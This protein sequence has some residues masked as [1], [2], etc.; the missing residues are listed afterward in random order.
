[1]RQIRSEIVLFISLNKGGTGSTSWEYRQEHP[2]MGKH[3]NK[4]MIFFSLYLAQMFLDNYDFSA[5]TSIVDMGGG[6]G[7]L[8]ASILKVYKYMESF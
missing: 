2:E 4:C 8:L 3:F 6:E 7:S 1:M 5:F